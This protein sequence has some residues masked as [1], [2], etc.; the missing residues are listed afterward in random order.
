LFV[1]VRGI[2][3]MLQQLVKG[4]KSADG[5]SPFQSLM[6]SLANRVGMGNIGGVATAIAFGG[7]GAV[8]WMWTVA[9]LGASTSFIECALGQIYKEKGP[10]TGKYRGGPSYYLEKAF[11]HTVVG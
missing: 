9:F 1:Q 8:F 7:P 6:M 10:A 5:T 2:P 3:E 4:E 11:K